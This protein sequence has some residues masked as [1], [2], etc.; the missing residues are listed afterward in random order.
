[1]SVIGIAGLPGSGKSRLMDR[2][3]S[4]G[5]SR[6]N[7]INRDWCGN[8]SKIQ[9]E[10]KQGKRVAISDIM[11]CYESWRRRLERELGMPVQ[12]IFLENNWWQ[13]ARNCLYRFLFEKPYRPLM[14]EIIKLLLLSARYAPYGDIRAAA[15]AHTAQIFHF[16]NALHV[17]DD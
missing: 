2:L 14:R 6:Y 16:T 3:Q 10:V 12:W 13:C 15:Q 9:A 17:S 4:G 8:L 1:M 7:D 5:Y 11:F